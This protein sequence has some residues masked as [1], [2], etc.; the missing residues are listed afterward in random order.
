MSASSL[1]ILYPAFFEGQ[2][3]IA[4]D[5]Y[6][7]CDDVDVGDLLFWVNASYDLLEEEFIFQTIDL[8]EYSVSAG[9]YK[10]SYRLIISNQKGEGKLDK[11]YTTE[12]E[13]DIAST[14]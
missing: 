13:F 10:V 14:I 9:L 11:E 5:I 8:N 7:I 2:D 1:E 12:L 3:E 6:F 4:L